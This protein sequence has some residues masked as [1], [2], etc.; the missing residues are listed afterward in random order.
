MS[1]TDPI[2]QNAYFICPIYR[3]GI[4][5]PICANKYDSREQVE[6]HLKLFHRLP[7]EFHK[8]LGLQI[9]KRIEEGMIEKTQ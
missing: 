4:D 6:N 5:S 8:L 7:I 3:T 9:R 2:L 1:E